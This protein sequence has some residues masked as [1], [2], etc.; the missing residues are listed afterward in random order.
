VDDEQEHEQDDEGEAFYSGNNNDNNNGLD[1]GLGGSVEVGEEEEEEDEELAGAP[2]YDALLQ[3]AGVQ[4]AGGAQWHLLDRCL[5]SRGQPIWYY[6]GYEYC[7]WSRVHQEKRADRFPA[8]ERDLRI[9]RCLRH[10]KGRLNGQKRVG[11]VT[12][13]FG[14]RFQFY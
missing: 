8:E 10:N 13:F 5:S 12:I 2:G 1:V 7:L 4:Q 14:A 9:I 11:F 6:E 3:A